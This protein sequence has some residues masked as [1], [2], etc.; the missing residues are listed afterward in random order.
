MINFCFCLIVLLLCTKTI[1]ASSSSFLQRQIIEN[2]EDLSKVDLLFEDEKRRDR[3]LMD[4][5]ENIPKHKR[6]HLVRQLP[7]LTSDQPEKRLMEILSAKGVFKSLAKHFRIAIA[8]AHLGDRQSHAV[9]PNL[10]KFMYEFHDKVPFL[11][12]TLLRLDEHM[13]ATVILKIILGVYYNPLARSDRRRLVRSVEKAFS[14][15]RAVQD[16]CSL[17]N[18]FSPDSSISTI[19]NYPWNSKSRPI[20]SIICDV[21]E[22]SGELATAAWCMQCLGKRSNPIFQGFRVAAPWLLLENSFLE[23]HEI[24]EQEQLL[25]LQQLDKR[26]VFEFILGGSGAIDLASNLYNIY[27][28]DLE[29]EEE[30]EF[31]MIAAL[32]DLDVVTLED[33]RLTHVQLEAAVL[34]I[35]LGRGSAKHLS[36]IKRIN[37][38]RKLGLHRRADLVESYRNNFAG[39]LVELLFQGL[40]SNPRSLIERISHDDVVKLLRQLLQMKHYEYLDEFEEFLVPAARVILEHVGGNFDEL[41]KLNL[42]DDLLTLVYLLADSEED[43]NI[44]NGL[45]GKVKSFA[46]VLPLIK[47]K[48]LGR[49]LFVRASQR[50]NDELIAKT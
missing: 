30:E 35:M 29:E 40:V 18:Q 47:I 11:M 3:L 33:P 17:Y 43:M 50:L 31:G 24:D 19:I 45:K 14:V 38:L 49:R 28:D 23:K 26:D 41:V 12:S 4:V 5:Y 16:V 44:V 21:I 22:R 36:C 15:H 9:V 39:L 6:L 27:R 37:W 20:Q 10:H 46:R 34:E 2:L 1:V 32:Y 13:V 48:P 25:L 42:N 8:G 7:L